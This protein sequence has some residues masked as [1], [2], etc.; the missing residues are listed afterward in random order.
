MLA[1]IKIDKALVNNN[2]TEA[3]GM[4]LGES[5]FMLHRSCKKP[6]SATLLR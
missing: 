4:H 5:S 6:S 1:D 2:S 3:G